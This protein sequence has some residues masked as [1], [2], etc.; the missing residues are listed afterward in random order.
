M[1][2]CAGEREAEISHSFSSLSD[3]VTTVV[4]DHRVSMPMEV[5]L[6]GRK[7]VSDG[8]KR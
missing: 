1:R 4:I 8:W 6:N 2:K 5:P 3:G 7:S